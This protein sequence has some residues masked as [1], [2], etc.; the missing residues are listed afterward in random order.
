LELYGKL[1]VIRYARS[2]FQ[3]L[4][5]VRRWRM[6]FAFDTLLSVVQQMTRLVT[7]PTARFSGHRHRSAHT[8]SSGDRCG[9]CPFCREYIVI[10]FAVANKPVACPRCGRLVDSLEP[11]EPA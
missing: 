10:R 2:E 5:G 9:L 3:F 8:R 6:S 1:G 11:P 7:A 4:L